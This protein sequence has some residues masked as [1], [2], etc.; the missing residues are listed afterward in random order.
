MIGKGDKQRRCYITDRRVLEVYERYL[1]YR[2]CYA[3]ND[4]HIFITR[5]ES[6]MSTQGV[7]DLVTKYTELAGIRR[8]VTPHTFRHTFASMLVEEGSI[9][10]IFR[11]IWGSVR[12]LPL[13]SICIFPI[14]THGASLWIS[15]REGRSIREGICGKL[16]SQR[17]CP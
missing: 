11:S 12:F 9:C 1:K 8:K 13:R 5:F 6:P 17:E 14:R 16:S 10:P 7:R 4:R 3:K 2:Q 15:T